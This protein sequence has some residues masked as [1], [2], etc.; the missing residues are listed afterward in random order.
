MKC[1]EHHGLKRLA[2]AMAVAGLLAMAAGQAQ[3]AAEIIINN[4]NDPGVGFNDPTPAAPIAG[5]TGTTIGEQRLIAFT[6]AANIWGAA[7]TSSQPIIIN[8][9]FVP[10]TCTATSGVLGSAGATQVFRNFPNAPQADTWY[11]YALANK[12][13]GSYLGTPGSPQINSNFNANLGTP[14]CLEA[15]GWYYGLDG[16][17]GPLIDFVAVLQHEMGHGLGFQTFTSGSSGAFFNG[18]A[19]I[20]DHYLLDTVTGKVWKDMTAAERVASAISVDKLVWNGPAVTAAAPTVLRQGLPGVVISGL[21]AGGTAGSYAAG[22]ASFGAALST[23]ATSGQLMPVVDQANGTGLACTP[24]SPANARA[25]RGN[26]ALVDRGTC[27][28]A[29]KA[30]NVQNAGAVGVVIANNVA[31]ATPIAPGGGDP[32][33]TIP[34]AGL[35]LEDASV[36]KEALK[37]RTRTSSGVV[38]SLALFGNQLAGADAQGRV[39]LFAPN[40]FQGGSSVSHFDVTTTPNQ[41][42]EPS[43]NSNLTQSV[44]PPQDLTYTLFQDIGWEVEP[45][46]LRRTLAQRR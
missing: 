44:L 1:S 43:I 23:T 36:I 41:L 35:R 31:A 40:P 46:A 30:L 6:Y 38:A 3:A 22:E 18:F 33:V 12:I 37:R 39:K 10:Q 34:V 9:R 45:T 15:S 32:A 2:S 26:I 8:A 11:S 29:I 25:V 28:F 24:L 19:S 21:A 5:N 16:N 14:G 4:T 13:A 7:L 42:M 20:W 27:A 17:E